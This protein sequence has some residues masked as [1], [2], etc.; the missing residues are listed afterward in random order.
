MPCAC[1]IDLR[2][3]RYGSFHASHQPIIYTIELEHF[4]QQLQTLDRDRTGRATFQHGTDEVGLTLCLD[5]GTGNTRRLPRRQRQRQAERQERRHRPRVRPPRSRRARGPPRRLPR[6][7]HP[8]DRL[9]NPAGRGGSPEARAS[10]YALPLVAPLLASREAARPADRGSASPTR[11]WSTFQPAQVVHFSTG[12]DTAA[13]GM[14][15]QEQ[16]RTR[17]SEPGIAKARHATGVCRG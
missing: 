4:A 17:L 15:D 10:G 7:R 9:S 8:P 11:R 6:S 2:L 1:Q 13:V 12:L 14:D 5:S 3:E 16:R